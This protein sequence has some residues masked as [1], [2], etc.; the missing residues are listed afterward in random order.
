[1]TTSYCHLDKGLPVCV[2]VLWLLFILILIKEDF[3]LGSRTTS[4][5][6]L[7]EGLLVFVLVVWPRFRLILIKVS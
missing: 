4:Y 5:C 2:Y 1:M 7:D 3:S 6:T